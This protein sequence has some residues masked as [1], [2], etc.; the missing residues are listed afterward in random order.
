MMPSKKGS[1]QERILA[2]A[3]G[4]FS[5]VGYKGTST[6][7]IARVAEV[8]EV[9]IYR[10]YPNKRE[11]FKAAV[12]SELQSLTVLDDLV[13]QLANIEE[14]GSAFYLV[15]EFVC[16]AIASRPNLVRLVQFSALEFGREVEPLYRKYLGEWL[17][18]SAAHLQRW[19]LEG[20]LRNL[21]PELIVL[22]FAASAVSLETLCVLWPKE[23]L[24]APGESFAREHAKIWHAMLGSACARG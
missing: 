7:D 9:T 12:E 1:S 13:D 4:L 15:F 23:V 3:V 10:H 14:P 17:R 19:A 16:K 5:Q 2:A 20:E 11:L 22:A 6:R 18:A 8:N 24:N 21:D